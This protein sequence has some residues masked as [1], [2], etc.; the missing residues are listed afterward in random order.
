MAN[1]TRLPRIV[2]AEGL[3][4]PGGPPI[5]AGVSVGCAAHML[6]LDAATFPDPHAFRPE[7]WLDPTPAMLRNSFAFGAGPRQCIARNLAAA[8]LSWTAQ[9][10][11]RSDTLKGAR[12]VKQ[13]IELREWFNA[14]VVGGKVELCWN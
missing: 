4:V 11:L 3:R 12:P 6:Q 1:P 7:R 14:Q 5:P 13:E 8:E 9:A 2:P 10:L